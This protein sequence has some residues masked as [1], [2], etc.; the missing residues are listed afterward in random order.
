MS[1]LKKNRKLYSPIQVRNNVYDPD[2]IHPWLWQIWLGIEKIISNCSE[3]SKCFANYMW[4]YFL[5]MATLLNLSLHLCLSV[6]TILICYH[7]L[8]Q[9]LQIV[10]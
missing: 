4:I 6:P 1:Q 8:S 10:L 5:Q 3:N 7:T 2:I 9:R